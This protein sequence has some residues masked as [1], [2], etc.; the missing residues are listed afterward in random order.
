VTGQADIFETVA[1]LLSAGRRQ[2]AIAFVVQAAASGHPDALFQHAVWHLIG[3]PLA[4]DLPAARALLARARLAGQI[5]AASMEVALTANGSG[6]PA[7][8]PGAYRLLE[9]MAGQSPI[10]RAQVTLLEAMKLDRKGG[11][12]ALPSPE[13]L[14]GHP[15][16]ARYP[17]LLSAAECAEV[18]NAVEDIMEPAAVIDPRT[19][20]TIEHPVRTSDGAVIGPTRENLVIRAINVRL[21][22][23]TGTDVSQGEALMVLRYAPAQQYRPHIDA[24]PGVANQRIKTVLVYLND[25][26]EGGETR[27]TTSGLSVSGKTGDAIVFNNV[28][29]DGAPDHASQH[30]GLPVRDGVKW[31]ATRWIRAKP[32]D[33]WDPATAA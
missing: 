21:A 17:A 6:A 12:S 4:R 31:L 10:A 9:A 18:A 25:G 19:G 33:P 29:P 2:D 27:F 8:W 7:G 32:L 26:Y 3:D 1:R 11:P 13:I 23:V 24:L 16:V 14:A 28:T 20:R 30:A 5:D 15:R 22:A